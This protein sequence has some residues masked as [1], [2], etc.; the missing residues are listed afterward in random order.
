ML[1]CLL[2]GPTWGE[3]PPC[4][5][6]LCRWEGV[7]GCRVAPRSSNSLTSVFVVPGRVGG[8]RSSRRGRSP[9]L[10]APA[11]LPSARCR[12]GSG[13]TRQVE[14]QKWMEVISVGSVLTEI[15]HLNL[16]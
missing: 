2:E 8:G 4:P 15:K 10:Q 1:P 12:A 9:L 3:R 5:G 13:M 7:T 14:H 11:R 16:N 6:G